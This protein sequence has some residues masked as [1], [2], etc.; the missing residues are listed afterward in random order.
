MRF[1]AV[2]ARRSE[3]GCWLLRE[4]LVDVLQVAHNILERNVEQDLLHGVLTGK[5][6]L[7]ELV[8]E[9]SKA[10]MLGERL[11][12][13][14]EKVE[15]LRE[16]ASTYAG[17][18]TRLAH[19][20]SLNHPAASCIIPGARNIEQLEENV[21]ASTDTALPTEITKEIDRISRTW[22]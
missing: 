1:T 19:H 17:G 3:D 21:A 22:E 14:I 10:N 9:K 2:A 5:F 7:G 15:M 6:R 16:I 12:E 11:Q 13:R 18:M 8:S 4:G 20:F